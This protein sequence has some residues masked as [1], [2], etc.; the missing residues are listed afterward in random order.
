A[1]MT[2]EF[3][4]FPDLDAA[5]GLFGEGNRFAIHFASQ[6]GK[7]EGRQRN[8]DRRKAFDLL[9]ERLAKAVPSATVTGCR[10]GKSDEAEKKISGQLQD[11][12]LTLADAF[13]AGGWFRF[14]FWL[15]IDPP[16]STSA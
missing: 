11:V 3:Y 5:I 9:I 16:I 6:G 8:P 15:E 12:R 4:K 7:G 2:Y 14:D 10:A 13:G 1:A